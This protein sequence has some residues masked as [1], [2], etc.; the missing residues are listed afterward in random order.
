M[1]DSVTLDEVDRL[2]VHALQ[3]NPRASWRQVGN[4]LAMDSVTVARRW[5]RLRD[6]G[7][8][9]TTVYPS[10]SRLRGPGALVEVSSGG[11]SLTT[12]ELLADD[13]ECGSID[14]TSG[15]RDLILSVAGRTPA[16][17]TRYLL[18]RLEALESVRS[19]RTHIVTNFFSDASAWR[20]NVLSDD[21]V[22]R[23]QGRRS[24]TRA[25]VSNAVDGPFSEAEHAVMAQLSR[26]VRASVVDLSE[27]SGLTSRKV[28]GVLR[29]L[30]ESGRLTLRTDVQAAATGY[31]IAV[32]LFLRVPARSVDK[33]AP[34]LGA[35]PEARAVFQVAGPSNV[36]VAVW[37]RQLADVGRLEVAIERKYPEVQIVD[38][39]VSLRTTKRAGAILDEQGRFVRSSAARRTG[40][41]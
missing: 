2:I 34:Q 3:V 32:F 4:V 12:A 40:E 20:L 18:E 29:D 30:L 39:S 7:I 5:E 38:R 33:V 8:V 11:K 36:I 16:A 28:S 14:I 9:W 19:V 22:G 17:T 31:P 35:L 21:Q 15:G 24:A 41:G 25:D 13:L 10:L 26:N 27:R 37:L 23:L 1:Q 6:R